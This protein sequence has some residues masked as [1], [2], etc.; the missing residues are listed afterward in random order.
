M[1]LWAGDGTLYPTFN[2]PRYSKNFTFQD[3]CR[4]AAEELIVVTGL[5]EEN[6]K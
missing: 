1:P 2:R 3:F 6:E 5:V 4:E